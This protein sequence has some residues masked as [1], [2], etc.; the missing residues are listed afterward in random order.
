MITSRTFIYLFGNGH[1]IRSHY[2]IVPKGESCRKKRGS[3]SIP[4]L[5][6]LYE[7]HTQI[8]TFIHDKYIRV[9]NDFFK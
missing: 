2:N 6:A 4:Y 3:R 8:V 5:G 7:M 1:I 9:L